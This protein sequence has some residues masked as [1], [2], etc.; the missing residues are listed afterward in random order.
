PL[1]ATLEKLE[2]TVAPTPQAKEQI[3]LKQI[4]RHIEQVRVLALKN[5]P[6]VTAQTKILL[7]DLNTVKEAVQ[8]SA[9]NTTSTNAADNEQILQDNVVLDQ[10]ELA[11]IADQQKT[12][13]SSSSEEK[14]MV[15]QMLID[16]TTRIEAHV[17]HL[18]QHRQ[19]KTGSINDETGFDT[20]GLDSTTSVEGV[21]NGTST[22]SSAFSQ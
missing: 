22:T 12:I 1:R 15:D 14:R 13:D 6:Q 10:E 11:D 2:L 9:S 21:V 5:K 16:Q 19:N 7:N 3:R 4:K 20:E 18:I 8:A 17:D